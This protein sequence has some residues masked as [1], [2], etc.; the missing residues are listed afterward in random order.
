MA[1][2]PTQRES[3]Q[4]FIRLLEQGVSGQAERLQ[5]VLDSTPDACAP[6]LR[7]LTQL[8]FTEGEAREH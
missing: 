1:S 2:V 4:L 8:D 7:L 6:L 3:Q 5:E